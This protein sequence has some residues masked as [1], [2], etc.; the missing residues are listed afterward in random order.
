[1]SF[2]SNAIVSL[3]GIS[4]TIS[5]LRVLGLPAENKTRVLRIK[6]NNQCKGTGEMYH[7][8]GGVWLSVDIVRDTE[9]EIVSAFLCLVKY[10]P[11]R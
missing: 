9:A 4:I 8:G 11:Y 1:M 7:I 10:T 5:N 3:E 6:I 2:K